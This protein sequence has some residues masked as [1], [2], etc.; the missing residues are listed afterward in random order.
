MIRVG[1]VWH[2]PTPIPIPIPL[3]P[4]QHRYL[5]PG[6]L[7]MPTRKQE[8]LA[9]LVSLPIWFLFCYWATTVGFR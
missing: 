8:I 9:V 2:G 3:R 5:T 1:L 4:T 6:G 7:R